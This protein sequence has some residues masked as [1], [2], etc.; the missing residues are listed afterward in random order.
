MVIGQAETP[1]RSLRCPNTLLDQ[2]WA[3]RGQN[4]PVKGVKRGHCVQIVIERC[5]D[6]LSDVL[7][8]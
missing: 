4:V 1:S 8:D 7:K 2:L 6:T 3:E 5:A